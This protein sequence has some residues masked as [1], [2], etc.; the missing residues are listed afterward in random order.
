MAPKKA[1]A[2]RASTSKPSRAKA[3]TDRGEDVFEMEPLAVAEDSK[4]RAELSELAIEL[5][6]EAASFRSSLPEGMLAALGDAVRAMNCY[7]S[8]LIEGHDTH[9]IA[10]ERAL[11]E[12]YDD[13]PKQRDLQ[14]EAKAHISVQ[15]WIDEGG[16]RGKATSAASL[17]EIHKRFI[18][19]LPDELRWVS[20][21]TDRIEVVPGKYRD[22]DVQVGRH[23]PV[24]PGALPRFMERFEAAYAN[25]PKGRLIISA[26][27][28]HQRLLWIHP[29]LDGNGRVA[30]LMSHAM[31]S[32]ALNT[33]GIWSIA[34]GLARNVEEYKKHLAE[35][36]LP[37]RN[38]LDGRG[39]LSDEALSAFTS[40]FL[41]VCID[42]VKFMRGLMAPD[43]LHARI[44][45][46]ADEEVRMGGLSKNAPA[47]LQA[48]LFRGALPRGDVPE[49]LGVT[50]RQAARVT[51]QLH[52]FGVITSG[53]SKMPWRLALPAKLAY[54]WLPG[55]YPASAGS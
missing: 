7:Y 45:A 12:V 6:D 43:K 32:E 30:R 27:A 36:D 17:K 48:V 38:D 18:Q 42:Q 37:R 55:L 1:A 39:K 10:I 3:A 52:D 25:A 21:G 23:V 24:S 51:G 2:K 4:R 31:M 46:W 16:V 50:D 44:M 20:D 28:A 29:F 15:R 19:A 5:T 47:V 8:N 49:L 9:P 40:F 53:S 34:R 13:D 35:C 11:N 54:R 26:A 41:Q 22:R 14:L 33:S